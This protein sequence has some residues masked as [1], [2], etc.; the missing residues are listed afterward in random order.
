[1]QLT[2]HVEAMTNQT[3]WTITSIYLILIVLIIA[4]K[5]VLRYRLN[6]RYPQIQNLLLYV[7]IFLP[8]SF[9]FMLGNR[10]SFDPSM[11]PSNNAEADLT[12]S[13][14]HI[15]FLVFMVVAAIV[16]AVIAFHHRKDQT[17]RYFNGRMDKVDFTVFRIG[18]FLLSIELYKQLIFGGLWHGIEQYQW[19][20][21]PLQFCSVPLFFFLIAPWLK[22][23]K[24]K[25][26]TY[27][28]VGLYITLGGL[29]VMIV[30]GGVFVVDV[31]ISVHTMLWHLTMVVTG[32]Y[33]IFAKRIGTNPRQ[34]LRATLFLAGLVLLV[35]IVNI[36]F[37]FMGQY[38]ENGPDTFSGFFISPW[39]SGY[40]LPVLGV[41]QKALYEGPLPLGLS[42]TIFTLIYLLSFALGGSIVYGLLWGIRTLISKQRKSQEVSK[43]LS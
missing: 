20:I 35:Q 25:A 9:L 16:F 6:N 19:Y 23:A 26:S 8:A 10:W 43:T 1:M 38:I 39:E 27:E 13:I 28:F 21:F 18:L 41:W 22:N 31:S 33:L 5:L 17:T 40:R 11:L 37:H 15:A 30:G 4:S 12:Y 3:G 24:L 42:A 34:L 14:F 32:V 2:M 29:L 7:L 36:Q